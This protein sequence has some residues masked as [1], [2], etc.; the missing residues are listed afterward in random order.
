MK[1]R[2]S[3]TLM[4][5]IGLGIVTAKVGLDMMKKYRSGSA[6]RRVVVPKKDMEP[7]YVVTA[8][9]LEL[10]EMPTS[11]VP[12]KAIRDAKLAVGRTVLAS[13]VKDYPLVDSQLAAVGAG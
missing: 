5:A 1:L 9:D 13:V 3:I 12:A 4:V 8:A 7:G 6:G 10:R 2:T 11:F